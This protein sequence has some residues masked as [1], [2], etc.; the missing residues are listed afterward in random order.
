MVEAPAE[1]A[2]SPDKFRTVTRSP[3]GMASKAGAA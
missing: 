1:A 2:A 3:I